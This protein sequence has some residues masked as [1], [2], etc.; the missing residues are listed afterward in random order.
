MK[1]PLPLLRLLPL[2]DSDTLMKEGRWQGSGGEG[3]G[4]GPGCWLMLMDCHLGVSEFHCG[5]IKAARGVAQGRAGPTS[6]HVNQEC[7]ISAPEELLPLVTA[8]EPTRL[9]HS[10]ITDYIYSN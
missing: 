1:F 6:L 7:L 5:F 2:F 9:N 8:I 3:G 10:S 4:G